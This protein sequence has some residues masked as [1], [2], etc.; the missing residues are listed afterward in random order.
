MAAQRHEFPLWTI[1]FL[2]MDNL[3]RLLPLHQLCSQFGIMSHVFGSRSTICQYKGVTRGSLHTNSGAEQLVILNTRN[4]LETL[5]P[6][7]PPPPPSRLPHTFPLSLVRHPST[8]RTLH[9][10]LTFWIMLDKLTIQ[11]NTK[12]YTVRQCHRRPKDQFKR[13]TEI[14]DPEYRALQQRTK[15]RASNLGGC[16]NVIPRVSRNH[17]NQ[18]DEISR[19]IVRV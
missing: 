14:D 16:F 19:T 5:G 15:G 1:C 2:F 17:D 7:F 12:G 9:P 18:R 4:P 3:T 13:I 6:P 10:F 8:I 11:S